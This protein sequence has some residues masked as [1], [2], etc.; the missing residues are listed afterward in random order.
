MQPTTPIKESDVSSKRQ[1]PCI[2][3][4]NKDAFKARV[5]A[6]RKKG[7]GSERLTP[8]ARNVEGRYP[9]CEAI[10]LRIRSRMEQRKEEDR[11]QERKRPM[12]EVVPECQV[13]AGYERAPTCNVS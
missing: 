3:V 5:A 12:E 2:K 11:Q 8:H 7:K 13:E 6:K 9:P 4:H 1:A 10:R